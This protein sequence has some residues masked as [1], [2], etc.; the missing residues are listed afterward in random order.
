M[1]ARR[2]DTMARAARGMRTVDTVLLA[3]LISHESNFFL[4]SSS[5]LPHFR[6]TGL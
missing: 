6:E 5:F 4:L 1:S 3:F 2:D